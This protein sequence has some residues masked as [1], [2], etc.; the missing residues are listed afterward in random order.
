MAQQ[1]K[2]PTSIHENAGSIPGLTQCFKD[3]V[4][5]QA[6]VWM[7]DVAG[8]WRGCGCGIG[9]WLQ[10]QFSPSPGNFHMLQVRP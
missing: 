4:V 3:L 8:I 7:A 2:S 10:L 5:L 1:I 9:R 6:A